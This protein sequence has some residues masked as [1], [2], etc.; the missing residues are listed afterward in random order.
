MLNTIENKISN[1]VRGMSEKV[2]NG[3]SFYFKTTCSGSLLRFWALFL[4]LISNDIVIP[5]IP[6]MVSPLHSHN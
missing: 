5:N 3:I 2:E 6:S 4:K 1:S